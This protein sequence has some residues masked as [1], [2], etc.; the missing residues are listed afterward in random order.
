MSE[1]QKLKDEL[2]ALTSV[3]D[4]I[5]FVHTNCDAQEQLYN[6]IMEI[7]EKEWGKYY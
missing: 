7:I 5:R 2:N 6:E 1:T 4:K 3:I